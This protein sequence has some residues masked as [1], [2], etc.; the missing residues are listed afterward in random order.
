MGT[1]KRD[2]MRFDYERTADY[3]LH[4]SDVRFKLLGFLPVITAVGLAVAET[5]LIEEQDF[6]LALGLLGLVATC[7]LTIYDQRNTQIYDRLIVR[8]KFLERQLGLEALG[9]ARGGGAAFGGPCLDRP[10]RRRLPLMRR[11]LS[12]QAN[13]DG[14]KTGIGNAR[15]H[16]WIGIEMIWHDLGLALVYSA[17][18][19]VWVFIAL[20]DHWLPGVMAIW[21]GVA[22]F[23]MLVALAKRN[24]KESNE[25]LQVA[26]TE[27]M[28]S[29]EHRRTR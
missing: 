6:R 17:S 20:T 9:S 19:A 13:T 2:L 8:L 29:A 18:A 14:G 25:L 15:K 1:E 28:G 4:L 3:L 10:P 5:G 22:V 21:A 27:T 23:G 16:R 11:R 26:K 24:D 12:S 7:G